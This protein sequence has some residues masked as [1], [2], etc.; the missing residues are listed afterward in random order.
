MKPMSQTREQIIQ[1][2]S[3]ACAAERADRKRVECTAFVPCHCN[4][5]TANAL[6]RESLELY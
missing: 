6:T 1:G 5:N 3:L 4:G 2:R